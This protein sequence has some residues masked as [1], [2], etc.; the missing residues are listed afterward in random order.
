MLHDTTMSLRVLTV[1]LELFKPNMPEP[2]VQFH[3]EHWNLALRT[4]PPR[5]AESGQPHP[6]VRREHRRLGRRGAPPPPRPW[7]NAVK[8]MMTAMTMA[9]RETFML[10]SFS[11][12]LPVFRSYRTV[13]CSLRHNS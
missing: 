9:K 11:D 5:P 13:S 3:V 4:G 2:G 12:Q 1:G 8:G 7:A 6:Y 10:R